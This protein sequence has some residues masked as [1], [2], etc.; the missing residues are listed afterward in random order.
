[1]IKNKRT[2]EMRDAKP[3]TSAQFLG[4]SFKSKTDFKAYFESCLQVCAQ[5]PFHL[6]H[7][8]NSLL[9]EGEYI[10]KTLY[11]LSNYSQ[12]DFL[13]HPVLILGF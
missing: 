6:F 5:S 8:I 10:V 2:Y 9:Q 1:M 4:Q 12:K 11:L 7:N 13:F 3:M